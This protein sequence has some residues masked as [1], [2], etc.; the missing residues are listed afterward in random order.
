MWPATV[1]ATDGRPSDTTTRGVIRAVKQALIST[2]LAVRVAALN[3]REGEEFKAGQKLVEFDCRRQQATIAAAE[4]Q[5]LEMQLTVD[6]NRLL[7]RT[8]SVGKL[9]L[10]VSEARL[11]KAKA[12]TDALRSQLEQCIVTAPFDG[13]VSELGLQ[14]HETSQPGKPFIGLIANAQLEIDLIV[15]S[16]WVQQLKP[17]T[18]FVFRIDELQRRVD[19]TIARIGASVD[20]VSQT[21]KIIATFENTDGAVLPGMSG[22]AE[23]KAGDR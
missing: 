12:E 18:S 16:L 3:V 17:G 21:I 1:T 20:P 7:S 13:R 6:K 9:E 15:P 19:A 22:T 10:D 5:Q 23:F 11:A 2:D 4:A 8:Q 14:V